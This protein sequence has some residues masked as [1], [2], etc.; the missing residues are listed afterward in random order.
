M[1]SL[2]TLQYN[3][4]AFTFSQDSDECCK[5]FIIEAGDTHPSAASCEMCLFLVIHGLCFAWSSQTEQW[6]QSTHI[7]HVQGCTS[8]TPSTMHLVESNAC[9]HNSRL[10]PHIRQTFL[11]PKSVE[12]STTKKPTQEPSSSPA[13]SPITTRNSSASPSNTLSD[14][15]TTTNV[16]FSNPTSTPVVH[17]HRMGPLLFRESNSI[18]VLDTIRRTNR[19]PHPNHDENRSSGLRGRYRKSYLNQSNHEVATQTPTHEPTHAPT[20]RPT[21]RSPTKTP[22]RMDHTRGPPRVPSG[23]PN[24]LKHH[25]TTP[26]HARVP[27]NTL[28]TIPQHATPPRENRPTLQVACPPPAN[29]LELLRVIQ[30]QK[31][32]LTATLSNNPITREPTHAPSGVPTKPTG[33]PS[34]H[35]TTKEPTRTPTSTPS[36]N[37]TTREPTHAPSKKPITSNPTY[38]GVHPCAKWDAHNKKTH[39]CP[40]S[41]WRSNKVP[42]K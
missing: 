40:K 6:V 25:R 4:S 39:P 7:C 12:K 2:C 38:K 34:S 41:E 17:T 28:Q 27:S 20:P 21:T 42:T 24:R 33:A 11:L 23:T 5:T 29:Q 1:P 32:L 13:N 10:L 36:N 8:N 37:S 14:S 26:Q 18:S 9:S 3:A 15:S 31:N 30:P 22:E 16:P 19:F 35:P